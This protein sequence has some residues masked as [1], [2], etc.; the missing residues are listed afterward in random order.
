MP[1]HRGAN[2]T[3]PNLGGG[4]ASKPAAVGKPYANPYL[5]NN[6][7]ATAAPAATA[8]PAGP[9]PAA[10]PPANAWTP[11]PARQAMLPTAPQRPPLPEMAET[12]G[13]ESY[14]PV[15][16]VEGNVWARGNPLWG[17]NHRG[18]IYLFTSEQNQQRFMSN[19][20]AYAPMLSG[21]DPVHYIDSGLVIDGKRRHGLYYGSKYFLFADEANLQKFQSNPQR[22]LPPGAVR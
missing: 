3:M 8:P 13:L 18:R 5:N 17:A 20:D 15:T 16:L 2:N 14:C 10:S 6:A 12:K 1:A 11:N 7:N 22:Y 9:A 19:P 21:Y 4:I